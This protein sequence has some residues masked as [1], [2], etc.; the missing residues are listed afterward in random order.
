MHNIS[1]FN[2][3]P[4]IKSLIKL[5][6]LVLISP[7][8]CVDDDKTRLIAEFVEKSNSLLNAQSLLMQDF[9]V[10]ECTILYR[11]HLERY[12]YLL[13]IVKSHEYSD[14]IKWSDSKQIKLLEKIITAQRNDGVSISTLKVVNLNK[15]LVEKQKWDSFR[16]ENFFDKFNLRDAYTQQYEM[17]SS[18]IHTRVNQDNNTILK[19]K[20][21]SDFYKID[22]WA[23]I[24]CAIQLHIEILSIALIECYKEASDDAELFFKQVERYINNEINYNSASSDASL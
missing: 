6:K 14:F 4:I 8:L 7:Q 11:T 12:I 16:I 9:H 18:F 3:I 22:H 10:A 24:E 5:S 1:N 15:K 2:F 13:E 21:T 23:I 20:E 19:I 17:A